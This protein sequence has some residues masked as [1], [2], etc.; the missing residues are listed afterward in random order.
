MS[1]EIRSGSD[2]WWNPDRDTTGCRSWISNDREVPPSA[3]P[4]SYALLALST[5]SAC[6]SLSVCD[7]HIH[8]YVSIYGAASYHPVLNRCRHMAVHGTDRHSYG[9]DL[10]SCLMMCDVIRLL[11]SGFPSHT[12]RHQRLLVE[13]NQLMIDGDPVVPFVHAPDD[14]WRRGA[15]CTTAPKPPPAAAI[16]GSPAGHSSIQSKE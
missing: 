14:R 2:C 9:Y 6:H 7:I 8:I 11:F 3:V 15:A 4:E 10:L 12:L 16:V 5:S 1:Q 13:P